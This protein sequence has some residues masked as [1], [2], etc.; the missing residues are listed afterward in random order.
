MVLHPD[1]IN[2]MIRCE[3]VG[4]YFLKNCIPPEKMVK[5]KICYCLRERVKDGSYRLFMLQTITMKTTPEGSLLK[6]FGSHTDISHITTVNN[7]RLSIIGLQGEPSYMELDVY[8][9]DVFKDYIPYPGLT[10]NPLS[11]RELEVL[12]LLGMGLSTAEIAEK[13]FI[14]PETVTSHRKN[15]MRKTKT[16]NT[17]EL[18]VESLKN[19]I[20]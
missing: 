1:D 20:L 12:Q 16:R 18:I 8:Q 11:K 6:V 3:D 19:G 5:Y 10:Q 7:H 14:S 4:A 13:L 9:D 2:F 17:V 15:I